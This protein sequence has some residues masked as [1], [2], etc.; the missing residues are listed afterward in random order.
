MRRARAVCVGLCLVLAASASWAG[1]QAWGYLGWWLPQSWRQL[2]LAQLDRVLFFE[3]KMAADGA[4]VERQGWPE[5][6]GELQ[7]A[8]RQSATPLDLTLTLMDVPRFNALFGSDS[9]R[10]R[11]LDQ[12]SQLASH[13]SV[14]GLHLD[15]EI[16]TAVSAATLPVY[17]R[18]VRD[19]AQRLHAMQPVRQLSVF[20]PVGG[21]IA[22]YDAATLAVL[23]HVVLQGYDAHWQGSSQA[24]PLAPLRGQDAVT[25]EKAFTQARA[26]G[27]PASRLLFSFPLYGYEWPVKTRKPRSA[28]SGRGAITSF[29]P[30]RVDMPVD[31]VSSVQQ[32]VAQYGFTHEPLSASSY[33]QFTNPAGQLIEGW[34]EDGGSLRRKTEFVIERQAAG[35]AFF[36]LGY[37]DN[38]LLEG[39]LRQRG[40]GRVAP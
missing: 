8:L 25:W 20:L 2:P 15:V 40:E 11:L 17:R 6:W 30:I 36:L 28:T 34:F 37:D 22:L 18:F 16:Y 24:G 7:A 27:L 12:A 35:L 13:D 29:A 10:Q 9:A 1:P 4:I 38:Q 5:Q 3:L 14:A 31:I 32:R 21:E 33:Y 26:L 39:F 19:L 23:D